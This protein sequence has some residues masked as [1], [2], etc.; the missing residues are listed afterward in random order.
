MCIQTAVM[1]HWL[2]VGSDMGVTTA[3]L[4][5]NSK[6]NYKD[7]RKH[8]TNLWKHIAGSCGIQ[9][10]LA[11]IFVFLQSVLGSTAFCCWEWCDFSFSFLVF[12]QDLNHGDHGPKVSLKRCCQTRGSVW[13]LWCVPP[14]VQKNLQEVG[15]FFML[16]M[17]MIWCNSIFFELSWLWW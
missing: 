17:F 5:L 4:V 1:V 14:N 11:M 10:I 12:N 8:P 16:M 13:K 2:T 6:K 9:Q 3:Q 15:L 7:S